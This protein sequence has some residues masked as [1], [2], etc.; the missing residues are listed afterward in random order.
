MVAGMAARRGEQTIRLSII[1]RLAG[2]AP[3]RGAGAESHPSRALAEAK[4]AFIRDLN[5]L[6]NTRRAIVWPPRELAELRKSVYWYGIPDVSSM[7]G[8]AGSLGRSLAARVEEAIRTFEPRLSSPRVSLVTDEEG[9]ESRE[10]RLVIEGVLEI[11]EQPERVEFETALDV[12][13]G[14]LRL[15]GGS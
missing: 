3:E 7:S 15:S 13:S 14:K 6:L 12:A 10:V 5:W 8:G 9:R 4:A 2:N 1:D 11:D